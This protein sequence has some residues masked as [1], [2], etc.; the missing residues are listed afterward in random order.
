MMLII[1]AIIGLILLYSSISLQKKIDIYNKES[2]PV[3]VKVNPQ[4]SI[5]YSKNS[6]SEKKLVNLLDNPSKEDII[7]NNL[8]PIK[9]NEKIDKHV[10]NCSIPAYAYG[11]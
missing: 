11:Y 9:E 5:H 6:N 2:E 3:T 1:I 10:D 8:Y 4:K 7:E